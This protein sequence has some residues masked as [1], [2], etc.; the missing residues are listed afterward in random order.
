M[1]LPPEFQQEP[2]SILGKKN[3]QKLYPNLREEINRNH[4]LLKEAAQFFSRDT[5][6]FELFLKSIKNEEISSQM[7]N[8]K[9]RLFRLLG[10]TPPPPIDRSD[11]A[12]PNDQSSNQPQDTQS[13]S[14]Q[15]KTDDQENQTTINKN[16]NDLLQFYESPENNVSITFGT[17]PKESKKPM[18]YPTNNQIETPS[19][20]SSNLHD[21]DE[22]MSSDSDVFTN[23]NFGFTGRDAFDNSSSKTGLYPQA[24]SLNQPQTNQN[25][26]IKGDGWNDYEFYS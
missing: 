18:N 1:N 26:N 20:I 16:Q 25:K 7:R 21:P 2:N 5:I 9:D 24:E 11:S 12:I 3:Q 15:P 10:V 23:S 6:F 22:D 17:T 8:N 14:S 4:E 19:L 13:I